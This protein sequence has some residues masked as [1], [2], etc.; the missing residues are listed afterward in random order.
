MIPFWIPYVQKNAT[1]KFNIER[2]CSCGAEDFTPEVSVRA[3]SG[4][5]LHRHRILKIVRQKF[6]W[7]LKSAE[8]RSFSECACSGHCHSGH[9]KSAEWERPPWHKATWKHTA[10]NTFL[11]EIWTRLRLWIWSLCWGRRTRSFFDRNIRYKKRN[12]RQTGANANLSV[13]FS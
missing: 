11:S 13:V 8:L 7:T 5:S 2:L 10:G 9:G 3:I 12:D 4:N 6:F 1:L